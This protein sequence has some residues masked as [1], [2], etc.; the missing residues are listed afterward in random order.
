MKKKLKSSRN[1]PN[2]N[3]TK[4]QSILASEI[5]EVPPEEQPP[6]FSLRYMDK[7][8][9][10]EKCTKD[11]KAAFADT[12]YRLSQLTWSE[13]KRSPRHGLGYE[14]ID[15]NAIRG[16]IPNILKQDALFIAFRFCGMAPMVGYRDR[17]VFY[18]I[19]LDRDFSLYPH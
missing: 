10:L 16:S 13:I 5:I 19:W 8:Y 9:S 7:D 3:L 1:L 4:N 12:L 14:K 2:K 17:S 11:E 15:R 6:L 18:I